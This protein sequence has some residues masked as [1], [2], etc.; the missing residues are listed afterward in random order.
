VGGQGL[1]RYVLDN[2]ACVLGQRVL[3]MASGSGL[4]G[5]AAKLA[6]AAEVL[7]ADIDPFS[8]EATNLN[9]VLNNVQIATILDD[10]IGSD[11]THDVILVGDLFY[12]RDIAEPLWTWLLCQHRRG[13]KILIG[14]PGRTYLPKAGLRTVGDYQIKVSRALEDTEIK[15]T[16]VWEL[17]D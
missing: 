5:I 6:G 3:D 17:T 1:A 12:E 15:R 4:V 14:D 10:L 8:M 11:V 7:C 13:I 9:A 16:R 2:R